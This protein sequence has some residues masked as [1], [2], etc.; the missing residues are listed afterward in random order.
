MATQEQIEILKQQLNEKGNAILKAGVELDQR[1]QIQIQNQIDSINRLLKLFPHRH[2]SSGEICMYDAEM[3]TLHESLATAQTTL[4]QVKS[5][6]QQGAS[7]ASAT[8][9]KYCSA[10]VDMID[11][12]GSDSQQ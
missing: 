5:Y 8:A 7:T 2:E 12:S 1:R 10:I 6:A 3:R 9:A 11:S 4:A